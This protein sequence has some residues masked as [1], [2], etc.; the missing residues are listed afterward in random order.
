MQQS[1]YSNGKSSFYLNHLNKKTEGYPQVTDFEMK[2]K[3]KKRIGK[4]HFLLTHSH[5]Y[6]VCAQ[7]VE[8]PNKGIGSYAATILVLPNNGF[9]GTKKKRYEG[10]VGSLMLEKKIENKKNKDK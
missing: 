9:V 2:R 4:L 5:F 10:E 1:Y 7:P 8:N 3:E 6:F